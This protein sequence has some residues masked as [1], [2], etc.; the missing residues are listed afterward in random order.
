MGK[1]RFAVICMENNKIIS[2][3]QYKNNFCVLT[4]VNLLLFLPIYLKYLKFNFS[5]TDLVTCVSQPALCLN[6]LVVWIITVFLLIYRLYSWPYIL[7][8]L[9]NILKYVSFISSCHFFI[10]GL[11]YFSWKFA[12]QLLARPLVPPSINI[13]KQCLLIASLIIALLSLKFFRGLP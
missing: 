7:I 12:R 6:T 1:S 11:C 13:I 8:Y 3:Y 9:L 2:N 10:S 5:Q 4:S